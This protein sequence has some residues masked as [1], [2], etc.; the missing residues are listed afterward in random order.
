[1]SYDRISGKFI[2]N[3]ILLALEF[4]TGFLLTLKEIFLRPSKAISAYIKGERKIYNPIKFLIICFT[5]TF[6]GNYLLDTFNKNNFGLGLSSPEF[7]NKIYLLVLIVIITVSSIFTLVKFKSY[8]FF[9]NITVF[10]YVVGFFVFIIFI[11]SSV[12]TVILVIFKNIS[13][14]SLSQIS[15]FII[16]PFMLIYLFLYFKRLDNT[17]ILKSLGLLVLFILSF[18]I[19]T[20]LTEF[21]EPIIL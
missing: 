16:P 9:E 5:L 19:S 18:L 14:E 4:E 12:E 6:F 21:I 20:L 7:Q 1:M 8:N 2:L 15:G 17:S 3:K 10:S 13:L 11:S